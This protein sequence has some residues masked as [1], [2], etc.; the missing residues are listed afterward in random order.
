MNNYEIEHLSHLVSPKTSGIIWLTDSYLGPGLVGIY[1]L[2]YLLDGLLTKTLSSKHED[3]KSKSNF[4]LAENFGNPFF[5]G[6][7]VIE[8]KE[9]LNNMFVHIDL[10]KPLFEENTVEIFIYN[11]SKNTANYNVLKEL[12][13]KFKNINFKNLNI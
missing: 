3:R 9:D 8:K 6:H 4:F 10:I 2:N 13:G 1:E 7:S 11:R 5:V 12:S